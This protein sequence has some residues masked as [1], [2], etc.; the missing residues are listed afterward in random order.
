MDRTTRHEGATATAATDASSAG[1]ALTSV[2]L[3]LTVY[4]ALI[5]LTVAW[6]WTLGLFGA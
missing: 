6:N 3:A 4:G 5:A 2:A 1:E